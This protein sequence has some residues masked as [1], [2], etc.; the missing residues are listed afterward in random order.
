MA[1]GTAGKADIV[2]PRSPF[3]HG[4]FG[5]ICPDLDPWTPPLGDNAGEREITAHFLQMANTLMVEFPD[6]QPSNET[7]E[8][9]TKLSSKIP[10]AYTYFGQFIDHDITF[11]PASSLMRQNDPAGLMNHRTP[12]FDLDNVYGRGPDDSPYLY[13]QREDQKGKL[14][15]G[16]IADT[17]FPDL[18]RNAQGR[19]LIGDMRNDENAIVSQLQLSFLKAHNTLVDRAITRKFADPFEKARMSLRWLYQYIVWNDFVRRVT[20]AEIFDSAF[21]KQMF[22]MG[23]TVWKPGM[24]DV[25]HWKNQ[26]YMPVE[27]SVAAY[28]FGH[29]MVRNAYQTNNPVRGFGDFAP[30]FDKATPDNDLRG[31]G[32]IKIQNAIQWDWFLQMES[33]AGPFPQHTRKIDSKLANALMQLPNEP[34]PMNVL[35]FRNLLRGWRFSLPS[36][37]SVARKYCL[38]PMD[39]DPKHDSLWYYVLK[40]AETQEGGETLGALGSTI[41]CAVFSGLLLGDPTSYVNIAPCWTPDDDPLLEAGDKRDAKDWT[42]ASIIRIAGMPA[43]DSDFTMMMKSGKID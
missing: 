20:K 27:F 2:A 24:K 22:P 17:K 33:S 3:Y 39:I 5:R 16:E 14:L 23:R 15:L 8:A 6:G 26:P 12:R 31:F 21:E 34:V 7:S 42:L 37:T 35:G 41:V 36:G 13:D 29:S 1:H 25:F 43:S 32:P 9:V 28:R 4:P 38:P 30:L 40:E 10:A 19:A 18:P 11:D